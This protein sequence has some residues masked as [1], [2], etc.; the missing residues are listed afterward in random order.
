M[1]KKIKAK[2]IKAL[3]SGKYAQGNGWLKDLDDFYCCLGVLCQIQGAKWEP[4]PRDASMIPFL[5]RTTAQLKGQQFLRPFA[6]AG[7]SAS[8]QETLA[9]MN[10]YGES[11]LVIAD[12]IESHL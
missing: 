6:R 9:G 5:G 3:R 1:D 7:M 4:N 8:A 2:W 10:D 11:F 12:Y